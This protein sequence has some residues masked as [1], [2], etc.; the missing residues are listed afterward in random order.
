MSV[1]KVKN[2]YKS[3]G[4]LTVL[5]NVSFSLER[6]QKVALVGGNGTG[7]TTL[8]KIVTGIEDADEGTVEIIDNARIGYLPQDTTLFGDKNKTISDYLR[9]VSGINAIENQLN[10]LLLKIEDPINAKRYSE[11][12]E[13]F[14][15]LDGYTFIRRMEIM[16][17]G[18]GLENVKLSDDLSILSSGQKSKVVLAG[19]LLK[20]VD[21]LILDEPTN[22]LDLPALIW[23]EDFLKETKAACIIVSHDRKFLDRVA[24]KIFE[25]N[26]D[27]HTLTI[28]GGSYSDY[29]KMR[30]KRI[31]RQKEEY[32]L[33][34]KEI[35]RLQDQVEKKQIAA[36]RGS[37]WRGSDNDKYLRG[38]K[39]DRASKSSKTA[40]AIEKRIEQMDK[41]EQPVER[42][43]F[44][45]SLKAEKTPGVLDVQVKNVVAG[46]SGGFK[47]GPISFE[48][49]YG[50]RVCIMGLNGSGKS[51]LLK[52]ITG[53][54]PIL[55]GKIEIGSGII[56][57]NMMQE[58][59]TLPRDNTSLQFLMSRARLSQQDSYSK[60]TKFGFQEKQIKSP[61]GTLSPGERAR[62][63]LALFSAQSVNMLVLDEP[64]NHLDIEALEAL[65]ETL[66]S[67]R[68]TVLLVSHDRYFLEKTSLD[69]A[70]ILSAGFLTK[71]TDYKGYVK[72]AEERAKK[73]AKLL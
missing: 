37:H 63:L 9:A 11:I 1:I 22:N 61:I 50:D 41:I 7:K 49:R 5:S 57:G 69:C 72:T 20:G 10:K 53:Q 19:I 54:L 58:H 47:I 33:Q 73:L 27:S 46:Y 64:T 70:Y 56:I 65:E 51:T 32:G 25:L 8:L 39:R 66:E 6:G 71:V 16:L 68:G 42:D 43:V 24:K 4:S 44:E 55:D 35:E 31:S 23:L 60:L 12:H 13:K 14:E 59:E 15:Q 3:Y 36:V 2:L 45:I 28:V 30:E 17:T 67:Y 40:R 26:W 38:F 52:T 34:Q 29:I 48:I 62:L 21:L 18:F